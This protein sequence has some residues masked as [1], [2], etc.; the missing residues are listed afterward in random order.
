LRED[1]GLPPGLQSG[2]MNSFTQTI[3]LTALRRRLEEQDAAAHADATARLAGR[4]RPGA[5]AE[6]TALL[7]RDAVGHRHRAP[8]DDADELGLR[9][10]DAVEAP[11]RSAAT[12]ERGGEEPTPPK[13]SSRSRALWTLLDQLISSGTNSILM[14]VVAGQVLPAEFGAF[15]AAFAVFA[16]VIGFSKATGGQPLGIRYSGAPKTVFAAAAAKATGSALMLGVITGL[17]CAVVGTLLG[18]GVG[19]ALVTLAVVLPGL[20]VQD[21]WRQVFFAQG[22]PAAAVV[23]DSVWGVV[24]VIG[25]AVLLSRHVALASPML[26]AWGAAAAVAA[27]IGVVQAGFWP[28]PSRALDW[29]REHRDINGF[30]AAEFV[31]VQGALNATL[32]AIGAVS[33]IELLGALRGVQTVLGPTTIFAVGIVSWAIPEF[34]QR[35]DMTAAARVRAAY[36]LSAA[37]ASLGIVWGLG[38]LL[39]GEVN[40]GGTPLGEHLLGDTWAGTHHLLG[41]SIIQQ[42]GAAFTVGVSCMLIALGR[43][44]DTFR[45][46]IIMAP[47]L[48]LYPLIGVLVGGGTGAVIGFVVANWVMV[49]AWFRLLGRAAREA[50]AAWNETHAEDGPAAGDTAGTGGDQPDRA[51][52]GPEHGGR[53]DRRGE[54]DQDRR[55]GPGRGAPASKHLSVE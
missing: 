23:N 31:T 10:L 27:L 20:L 55:P 11:R 32:L 53:P 42:A 49:P 44:K 35:K 8:A 50:E 33:T 15:S 28:A 34:S 47:Q 14:F 46:N 48:L 25:V 12:W 17:G 7:H 36:L 38:F 52:D 39:L 30:L 37:V 26:L 9:E 16:V 5:D 29:V 40:A 22:R 18:G 3:D 24:Q 1:R 4:G 54:R 21:L 2:F 41:L 51:G 45:L 43:A 13:G 19:S 6:G